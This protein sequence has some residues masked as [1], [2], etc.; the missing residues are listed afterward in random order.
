MDAIYVPD[1]GRFVPGEYARGPWDP[2][3]QHGGPV[4]ALLAPAVERLPTDEEMSVVRLTVEFVRPVPLVPL[5]VGAEV[6]RPGRKMQ[7]L[8]ASAAADGIEV[9]RA[10]GVRIRTTG[11][12]FPEGF[13]EREDALP[14]PQAVPE[15]PRGEPDALHF[16]WAMDVRSQT[17]ERRMGPATVWM[18]LRSPL[19]AGEEPSPLMRVAAAADFGNG[20]SAELDWGSY[21]FLNTDL[22]ISLHR[23]PEG[24]W[25]GL[26]AASWVRPTG[27]GVTECALYDERGRIGRSLQSLFIDRR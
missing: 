26:D 24:D 9:A 12:P 27:V 2:N 23:P 20:V 8:S 14:P 16:W 6:S 17:Q 18:R 19:V 22:T 1:G 7:L 13:R 21:V 5:T 15:M 3:A 11:V 4:A 25:V 10:T